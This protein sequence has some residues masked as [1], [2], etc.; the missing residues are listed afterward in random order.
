M[1]RALRYVRL[2]AVTWALAATV[3]AEV[4]L[5]AA[6]GSDRAGFTL[7][8]VLRLTG[9]PDAVRHGQAGCGTAADVA[10]QDRVL[11]LMVVSGESGCVVWV[12]W[13]TGATTA[14]T[15]ADI[16]WSVSPAPVMR[17]GL[18]LTLG[19]IRDGDQASVIGTAEVAA[20][21]D[22][23]PDAEAMRATLDPETFALRSLFAPGASRPP[24]SL[25]VVLSSAHG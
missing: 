23:E 16:L 8:P 25:S 6:A 19:G 14:T 1:F 3:G 10:V 2:D 20:W 5:L 18:K 11:D 7:R 22:R 15:R 24:S 21:S 13:S 4:Q 9:P 17:R 12:L